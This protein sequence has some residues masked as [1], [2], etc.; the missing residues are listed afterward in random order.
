[1]RVPRR[2]QAAGVRVTSVSLDAAGQATD[3]LGAARER[4]VLDDALRSLHARE[5]EVV[6]LRFV[7]DLSQA[8]IA[9]RTGLSQTHVSRT[10]RGALQ[11]LRELLVAGTNAVT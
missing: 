2:L 3:P 4:L 6:R 10:L 9:A 7:E 5:R 1:V 8:Q 11:R